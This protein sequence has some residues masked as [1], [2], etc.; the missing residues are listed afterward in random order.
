MKELLK[1]IISCIVTFG[2]IVV[3]VHKLGILVRPVNTDVSF[4]AIDTFHNMPEDSLEVIG[5][6]S[7]HMQRGMI[8]MEMYEK[9]GIGA[10]NYGCNWQ[11]I[12]TTALFFKESLLTQSPKIILIETY[13]V[14]SI[15]QDVDMDG[16]IYYTR[17]LTDFEGKD[18]FLSQCFGEDKE[19]YLSYYMPLCAFHDNW[20]NLEEKSFY[21]SADNTDFY[22]SMGFRYFDEVQP[23]TIPDQSE[24]QQAELS[25]GTLAILDDIVSICNENNI[26][27][28]FYTAPFGGNYVYGD[29]LKKYA[30]ANDC[31]YLN[32]FE[33]IDEIG[34]D[35][36]TDFY[37]WGHLNTSG[38]VKVSDFLGEYI[39]NN[40]DVTDMR[41]IEG[42]IWEQNLQ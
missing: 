25:A 40:Y 35:G 14:N 26:D 21:E 34:I 31:V 24:V 38:A 5:Y 42:N 8:P 28:I 13:L 3:L 39:V 37:D 30:E 2:L 11:H 18:Q 29:A 1:N 27:I 36:Q 22:S 4:N 33:Y 20:I 6:G 15:F 41:T 10:Y 17:A 16:E 7:S 23:V 19:R 12:N 9:Y 32:L